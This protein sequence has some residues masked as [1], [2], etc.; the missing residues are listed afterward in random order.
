MLLRQIA[1]NFSHFW[2]MTFC[3]V[4]HVRSSMSGIDLR[5]LRFVWCSLV[6]LCIP[7]KVLELASVG[8]NLR[9]MLF[10]SML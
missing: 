4:L 3:W 1:L 7:W 9:T 10:I 5:S 6:H 2:L 8:F